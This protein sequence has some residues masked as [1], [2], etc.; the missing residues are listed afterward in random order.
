MFDNIH[1]MNIIKYFLFLLIKSFPG[2]LTLNVEH[3]KDILVVTFVIRQIW[4]MD[5][6]PHINAC[7]Q[8]WWILG[9]MTTITHDRY[10]QPHGAG[11]EPKYHHH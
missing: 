9:I 11:Q 6:E 3:L 7:R 4:R 10:R 2:I 8:E 1:H 5:G